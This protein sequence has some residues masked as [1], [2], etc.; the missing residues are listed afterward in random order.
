MMAFNLDQVKFANDEIE[1]LKYKINTCEDYR[2]N[3]L[4][5]SKEYNKVKEYFK[6]LCKYLRYRCDSLKKDT[7][8]YR[9]RLL[10]GGENVISKSG[11]LYPPLQ[12]AT[13]GRMNNNLFNV[14]YTSVNEFTACMET[15]IHEKEI[16]SIFQLTKF[17]SKKDLGV[18]RLGT[19]S[20]IY[21]NLP[22]NSIEYKC[23]IESYGIRSERILK[24]FA[25]LENLLLE[26]L[27]SRGDGS[28]LLSSI[29]AHAI[30]ETNDDLSTNRIDAILYPSQK[31]THGINLAFKTNV[32]D[33][34]EINYTS[35][36]KL[37]K[38]YPNKMIEYRTLKVC[39][40]I[41]DKE[42]VYQKY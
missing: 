35:L 42:I 18:Y 23:K 15:E 28:Y 8:F 31:S 24:G 27:Y 36:N 4:Q 25:G 32:A 33:E 38:K 1:K 13:L 39:Y 30:F 40:E 3:L 5:N 12:Q 10:E 41:G 16:D 2:K 11:L 26:I 7:E 21:F 9:V 14:M 6:D 34:L 20:E 29:L 17:K 37:E 22:K 19:F